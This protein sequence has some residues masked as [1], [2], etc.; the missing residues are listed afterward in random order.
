MKLK[1][2]LPD[3]HIVLDLNG[4]NKIDIIE[5]LLEKMKELDCVGS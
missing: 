1:D 3:K 4:K 2:Y 5:E